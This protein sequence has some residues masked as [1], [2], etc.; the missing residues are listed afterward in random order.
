MRSP[1][2]HVLLQSTLELRS[3]G[4]QLALSVSWSFR[5]LLFSGATN[6]SLEAFLGSI[7]EWP[8]IMKVVVEFARC[9]SKTLCS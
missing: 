7:A 5:E 9:A 4:Q 3:A 6:N 1:F 8:L 2:L